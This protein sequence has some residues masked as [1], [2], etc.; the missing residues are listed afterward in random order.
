MTCGQEELASPDPVNCSFCLYRPACNPF[1]KLKKDRDPWPADLRGKIIR[2]QSLGNG[3]I[4]IILRSG[5]QEEAIRG[6]DPARNRFLDGNPK[7]VL[8]C[9]LRRETSQGYYAATV[10]TTGYVIR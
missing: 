5:S 8:F 1:W 2:K 9:N 6:L 3:L 10:Y 4:R 7:E